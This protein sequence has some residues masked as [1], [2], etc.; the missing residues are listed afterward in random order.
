MKILWNIASSLWRFLDQRNQLLI[1]SLHRVDRPHGLPVSTVEKSLK[2]LAAH[3]RFVLPEE[4]QN[5]KVSGKLAMLTVDDGHTEVFST[6]YPLIQSL[7]ISMVI[8]STTNFLLR[9]Q[10]LWF[11]KL[12]WIIEQPGV[13]G[14]FSSHTL[15]PSQSFPQ[16]FPDLSK[17]CKA[18]PPKTRD[19]LIDSLADHLEVTIPLEPTIGFRPVKATDVINM[20]NSG[21]VE[22]AS[23]T[24]SHPILINLSDKD[25]DCELQDSKRD[26]ETFSGRTIHSFC[27]P[28][29]LSGD[30]DERTILAV[31]K[32]G[33]SM[34]FT[35]NEGINY[36][37]TMER[38]QL[39]RIHIHRKPHVFYRS[40]SGLTE[41]LGQF[42]IHKVS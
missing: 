11:D 35:S 28:N 24:A 25:L 34:A 40:T 18:L 9:N 3:Y 21:T 16:N 33:Y 41:V 38:N 4:L 22:L 12:R 27:Y 7:N 42:R 1:V 17:Y 5:K 29:G 8:C 13:V 15:P 6:L 20:L 19:E 36:N 23:H 32:A 10:W 26:L 14:R 2:F 30:Y 37:G 39:K 31:D